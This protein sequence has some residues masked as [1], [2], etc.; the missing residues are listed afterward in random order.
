MNQIDHL[1]TLP[2]LMN[3]RIATVL[4]RQ[5]ISGNL[6]LPTLK[7]AAKKKAEG[8]LAGLRAVH[9]GQHVWSTVMV[10][11]SSGKNIAIMP[12]IGTLT[13][14]GDFCGYGMRDYMSEI[15]A[16]NANE[17]ISAIVMDMEGPGGTVDG[18]PEFGMVVNASK[19]PIVTFGDCMVASA[20][21]WIASQSKYIIGNKNNPTEFG[22]I[23][24][25]CVHEY[26]GKFIEE[27]IGE[28]KIIRA[29]QSKDK[30]LENPLEPLPKE[31]EA[32]IIAGLK[33]SAGNF[34]NAVKTGRGSALKADEKVW[35]TGKM[36]ST[37][38]CV[39]NGLIDAEGSLMDA[40][41]KAAELAGSSQSTPGQNKNASAKAAHKQIQKSNSMNVKKVARQVSSYF[42][43]KK[44]ATAAAAESA[45][46]E[47]V[48]MWTEDMTFNTDGSGDGAMCLHADSEGNDRK[49][50]TKIDNNT[51]NEP[52]VDPAVTEDDNW[53]VV[54]AA[55]EPAEQVEEE[56]AP[57][58]N[59][60]VK[61]NAA[62]KKSKASEKVL[63]TEV[64]TLKAEVKTLKAKMEKTPAGQKTTV[65]SAGDPAT[66]KVAVKSWEKKAEKKVG[67]TEAAAE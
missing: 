18:T 50:E 37:A 27:N 57:E 48:P 25:F 5:Y 58:A 28:V 20:D 8:R 60:A 51:G 11:H 9:I 14:R 30:I 41:N 49:F 35:G 2:W 40:I 59:T 32:E 54:A 24:V 26:Y 10:R 53:A 3:E 21:Y 43:K 19:K 29:P 34:I 1:L 31:V 63:A 7:E 66:R 42:S 47:N 64:A 52:P 67:K 22:S 13:K 33:I 39:T 23:G 62:L 6:S 15:D 45:A 36:F 44:A 16:L 46:E 12:V 4:Y 56:A 55:E 61:L 17:E 65:V 38:E